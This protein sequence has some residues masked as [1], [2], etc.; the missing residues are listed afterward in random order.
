[1]IT[2]GHRG[3]RVH[4]FTTYLTAIPHMS[5]KN[6]LLAERMPISRHW[7]RQ[8]FA[9]QYKSTS[10][11]SMAIGRLKQSYT[12]LSGRS[13]KIS[14]FFNRFL[15]EWVT[16]LTLKV[17]ISWWMVWWK[18]LLAENDAP[19]TTRR[20]SNVFAKTQR[21]LYCRRL[22]SKKPWAIQKFSW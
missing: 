1:M 2:A 6:K 15:C 8:I 7:V 18:T 22:R 20:F 13:E 14:R 21:F 3:K 4:R 10:S 12:T 9:D 5:Y 16:P 19:A 17:Q 11:E